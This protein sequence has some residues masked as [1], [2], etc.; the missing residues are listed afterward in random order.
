MP[1]RAGVS[2]DLNEPEEGVSSASWNR[3]SVAWG[4]L[5]AYAKAAHGL[6]ARVCHDVW[7]VITHYHGTLA[8]CN[9][10]VTNEI[11]KN[12]GKST[13]NQGSIKI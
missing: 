6:G 7:G 9:I 13:L 12:H 3:I 10:R 2:L 4:K 11:G 5:E 1:C 8:H